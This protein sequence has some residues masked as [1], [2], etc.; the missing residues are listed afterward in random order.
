MIRTFGLTH[1]ALAV[2]DLERSAAFYEQALGA[3]VLYRSSDKIE[4]CTAGSLDVLSLELSNSNAIG[5]TGGVGHFGFRLAGPEDIVGA[6][7]VIES[8]GGTVLRQGEFAPGE[9]FLFARDPD[10]YEIEFWYEPLA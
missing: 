5:E 3:R 1:I 4:L 10:G 2:R 6:A 8:A 7:N 9:P